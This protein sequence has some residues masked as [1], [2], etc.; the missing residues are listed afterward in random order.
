M[1]PAESDYMRTALRDWCVRHGT[2]SHDAALAL[3][4]KLNGAAGAIT[5][6]PL[7][8]LHPAPRTQGEFEAAACAPA[9]GYTRERIQQEPY[10][11]LA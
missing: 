7:P 3:N 6:I 8:S 11:C 5:P 2:M 10:E 9:I 4:D 1:A